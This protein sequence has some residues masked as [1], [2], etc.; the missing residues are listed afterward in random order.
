MNGQE[1]SVFRATSKLKYLT[2]RKRQFA[3][4]WLLHKL[5]NQ[6]LMDKVGPEARAKQSKFLEQE[7]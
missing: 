2:E 4:V 6:L 5:K 3:G 1:S 7:F